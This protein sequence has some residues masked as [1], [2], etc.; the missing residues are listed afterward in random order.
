MKWVYRL[1]WPVC[2]VCWFGLL[3][4]DC[5]AAETPKPIYV[6]WAGFGLAVSI[7]R[8]LR[9]FRIDRQR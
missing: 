2:A 9:P 1:Y 6:A 7:D 3:V 5:T 8:T 4:Y